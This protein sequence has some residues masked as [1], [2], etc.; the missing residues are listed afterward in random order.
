M[1]LVVA[2]SGRV[3]AAFVAELGGWKW[4]RRVAMRPARACSRLGV[5]AALEAERSTGVVAARLRW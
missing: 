2:E 5:R 1:R 3:S 4:D